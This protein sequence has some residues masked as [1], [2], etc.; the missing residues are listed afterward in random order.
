MST[1]EA[2]GSHLVGKKE[3]FPRKLRSLSPHKPPTLALE[4]QK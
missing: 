2:E 4:E 3:G 1:Q